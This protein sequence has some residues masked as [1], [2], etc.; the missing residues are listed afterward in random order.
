MSSDFQRALIMFLER[1]KLDPMAAIIFQRPGYK[2]QIWQAAINTF[3]R[4]L[5]IGGGSLLRCAPDLPGSADTKFTS[6]R[7]SRSHG[8]THKTWLSKPISFSPI[9]A[10]TGRSGGVIDG[11]K[12]VQ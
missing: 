4:D 11:I 6:W 2:T 9:A 7:P 10:I 8:F 1:E 5:A 3:S 12:H